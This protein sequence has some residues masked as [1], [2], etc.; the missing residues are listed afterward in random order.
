[1]ADIDTISKYLIQRYP[2]DFVR[3]SLSR[4]DIEVLAVLDTEQ[5][6]IKA[7]RTDSLLR[8]RIGDTECL[9]HTE[10]QTTDRTE[11]P[12][13]RRM[14]GYIGRLVEQYGLPVYA[15][16]IYLRPDAGRR[17]PG[18]YFQESPGHRILIEYQVI[19]LSE[20]A[21]QPILASGAV[22]LLPFAPLMQPAGQAAAAWL[23]T[24]VRTVQAQPLARSVKA[25]CL[26]GMSLLSGLVY[27]PETVSTIFFKEGLMDLIRESPVAQYLTQ[28]AREEGI[29]QGRQEGRQE[30]R[31]HGSRERAME[32]LLD[33][34]EIRF[35]VDT[36]DPLAASIAA[37]DDVQRLKQLHRAAIQV[38][39]LEEFRLL[40]DDDE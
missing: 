32:A 20:Q 26:A 25:D 33:V 5:P 35:A 3:F 15:I 23:E 31:E 27:A 8:V 17:D 4:D 18:H 39:S 22:G 2:D 38:P 24:C 6:T 1:M 19:R 12:M 40:L 34:L 10:F 14:A 36:A 16:V 9:V 7:R 29:E 11:P 28:Q 30:G 37:I 13:P 21:G